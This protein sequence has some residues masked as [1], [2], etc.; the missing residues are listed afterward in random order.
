M[1][2]GTVFGE[3]VDPRRHQ[4]GP[5]DPGEMPEPEVR[6]S[7]DR[8]AK[9]NRDP[10]GRQQLGSSRRSLFGRA[11]RLPQVAHLTTH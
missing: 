5:S 8:V 2:S 4:L 3:K 10:Q 9:S 11:Q 7:G 6:S 1:V